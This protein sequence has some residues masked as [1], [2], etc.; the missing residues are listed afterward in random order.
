M[1]SAMRRVAKREERLAE[2]SKRADEARAKWE[3]T[4]QALAKKTFD[5]RAS[6]FVE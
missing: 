1:V 5:A 6:P 4:R 2:P 3:T